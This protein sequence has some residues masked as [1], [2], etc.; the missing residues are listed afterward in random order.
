MEERLYD[1]YPEL[2]P[3]NDQRGLMTSIVRF[4]FL[5]LSDRQQ[6]TQNFLGKFATHY[7][8]KID[9]MNYPAEYVITQNILGQSGFQT[10]LDLGELKR[11]M[12]ILTFVRN[13]EGEEHKIANVPFWY[14]P[15]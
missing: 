11:G 13:D 10:Y 15:E 2:M 3:E 9:G 1:T 5:S 6:R 4:D 14:F 7:S 12:H 8:L